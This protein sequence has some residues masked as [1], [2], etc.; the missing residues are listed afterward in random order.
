MGGWEA[1]RR[2]RQSRRIKS[3][4]TSKVREKVKVCGVD[5]SAATNE[6]MC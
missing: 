5:G 2:K 6:A 4:A 1:G 3:N